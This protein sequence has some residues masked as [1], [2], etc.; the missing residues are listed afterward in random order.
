MMLSIPK[1]ENSNE[2]D[3]C[4]MY[5]VNFTEVLEAGI[6]VPDAS[7]PK[8]PC[9]SGWEYDLSA[10]HYPSIVTEVRPLKQ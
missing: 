4:K 9:Q 7:W 10:I 6:K 1:I 2:Y 3:K 8:I 5:G